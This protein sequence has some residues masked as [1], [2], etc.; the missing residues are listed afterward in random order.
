MTAL[1]GFSKIFYMQFRIGRSISTKRPVKLK[2]ISCV[3]YFNQCPSLLFLLASN[4][5]LIE[6]LKQRRERVWP[7]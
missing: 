6:L 2:S 5:V 3:S 4:V 7:R 1:K